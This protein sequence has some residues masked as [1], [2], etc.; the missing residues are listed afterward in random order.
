[1]HTFAKTDAGICNGLAIP[2]QILGRRRRVS[3]RRV[4]KL[5]TRPSPLKEQ[6]QV[7]QKLEGPVKIESSIR[8]YPV[9]PGPAVAADPLE[10]RRC[11]AG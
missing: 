1:M 8:G 3:E 5:D 11:L 4:A 10:T 6:A 2:K 7:G 9:H